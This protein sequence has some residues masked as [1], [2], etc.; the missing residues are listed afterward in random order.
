MPGLEGGIGENTGFPRRQAERRTLERS[1]IRWPVGNLRFSTRNRCW[2]STRSCVFGLPDIVELAPTP[3]GNAAD[4]FATVSPKHSLLLK[5]FVAAMNPA[6]T[7]GSLTMPESPLSWGIVQQP[8]GG[9]PVSHCLSPQSPASMS[10]I[11]AS[12]EVRA[13]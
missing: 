9:D 1:A 13:A 7:R 12:T 8:K 5:V 2:S 4:A 6:R 3:V 10:W 11:L